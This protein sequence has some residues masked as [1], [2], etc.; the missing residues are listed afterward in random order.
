[1][2]PCPGLA[3]WG[4]PQTGQPPTASVHSPRP[5]HHGHAGRPAPP[6]LLPLRPPGQPAAA[7]RAAAASAALPDQGAELCAQGRAPQALHQLAAGSLRQ[8]SGPAGLPRPH[9]RVPGRGRSRRRDGGPQPVRLLRRAH[10]RDLPLHLRAGAQEG[11]GTLSRVRAPRPSV[12]GSA[13]GRSPNAHADHRLRGGDQPEPAAGGR[14]HRPDGAGDPD[15]RGDPG[16]AHGLVPGFRLAPGPDAAPP[17]PR[18]PFRL[19]LPDPAQARPPGAGR[20]FRGRG[21]LHRPACLDRG[22]PPRRRLDR[23]RPHLGLARRRRPSAAG[24]HARSQQCRTDHGCRRSVRGRVR[25]RDERAAHSRAAAGH[26]AL[27]RGRVAG[28]PVRGP[29]D[30]CPAAGGRCPAHG[31]RRADLRLHRRPRCARVEHGR[32]GADQAGPGR[33]S[34]PAAA[35]A[36]RTGRAAAVRP[37][38]VVPGRTPA[39]LGVRPA[40]ARRRAAHVAQPGAGGERGRARGCHPRPCRALHAGPDPKAGPRPGPGTAGVRGSGSFPGPQGGAAAQPGYR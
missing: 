16:P 27:Q 19:W 38:Q 30:R 12:G 33:R 31:R 5:I 24:L 15:L 1:M 6:H 21:G 37:G 34:D 36:L 23:A 29:P 10:R 2:S 7:D 8:L 25:L 32:G 40:L 39:A 3:A 14:L 35:G 22:V 9:R 18:R 11:P 13:C 17:R 28:D 20:T 4:C 26:Q